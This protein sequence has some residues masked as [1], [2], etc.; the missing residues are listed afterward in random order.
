MVELKFYK[1]SGLN[2]VNNVQNGT[3]LKLKNQV[4]YNVNYFGEEKRCVGK[5]DFTVNDEEMNPFEI[6]VQMEAVFTYSDGDEQ[7]DIHTESFDQLFPFLRQVI[8][9]TTA[10]SGMPGLLIPL[11]KLDRSNVNVNKAPENENSPLN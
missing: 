2:F 11:M 1:V 9:E 8:H 5:L 4:K 6:R 7:P 3:Q 10:M